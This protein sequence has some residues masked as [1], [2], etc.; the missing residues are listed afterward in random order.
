MRDAYRRATGLVLLL[1]VCVC[2][3]AEADQVLLQLD[4][5]PQHGLAVVDV[6]LTDAARFCELPPVSPSS[7][8]AL[9]LP[10]RTPVPIQ[11]VP[12]ADFDPRHRIAG[13]L[14]L[15]L[16]S[17]GAAE[18]QLQWDAAAADE[19]PTTGGEPFAGQVAT[20]AYRVTH[21]PGRNGGLPCRFEF[22]AGGRV[23]ERFR[24]NDRLHDRAAGSA[25]LAHDPRATVQQVSDGPL[26]TVIRVHARY[27]FPSGQ[28]PESRPQAVYDW[29][30]FR[31]QPLIYVAA[32][33]AQ[34]PAHTWN[35]AHFLELNFPGD[36][37]THWAG[38]EP[39]EQGEFRGETRSFHSDSWG[40]LID[41][42]NAIG[43]LG[44]G[45]VL[46]YDHR[47]GS[48]IQAHGDR[49]WQDWSTSH[50]RWSGWLWVGSDQDAV[51][52]IR[53]AHQA[54]PSQ[55]I[56]TIAAG[57]VQAAIDAARNRWQHS[58]GAERQQ[59]WWHAAGSEQLA[60]QGRFLQAGLAAAGQKPD[61]WTVLQAG[62][63]GAIFDRQPHGIQL[64]SLFDTVTGRQLLS[65]P[66][67]PLFE[68]VLRHAET[69]EEVRL[70][71]DAGWQQVQI[72]PAE[73][74]D[75]L[76]LQWERPQDQRLGAVTVTARAAP[77]AD[78]HSVS[79]RLQ[80]SS[81]DSDWALWRVVF[82][83]NSIAAPGSE[84]QLLV[85]HA[86]GRLEPGAWQRPVRFTGRYPSGWTSMQ[87]MAAYA[88]DGSVGFYT[89]THDPQ[90][91]T[92]ELSAL[93][94][95]DRHAI[96][97]SFDHPVPD[98]GQRG[99]QF[100]LCGQAVWQLFRGDWFDAAVIYRR[101][102]REHAAWFPKLTAEGRS[103][104][105]LWMRQLHVWALG[106]GDPKTGLP[107]LQQFARE[108]GLPV[109]FHWYNWHQIPFDN[110][111]PHYFPADDGFAEAVELLQEKDIYVMPYIN[112]RLW[113][114]HDRGTEDFQ[115]GSLARPAA[116]KDP[117]GQPYIETYGSQESDGN[118]V[119][120][121]AMC[122][123]TELWQSTVR[124]TVLRLMRECQVRGVYIDQVAAAKPELCFDASHAHPAGGGHW[125]TEAYGQMLSDI[126]SEMP[127]DRILTT[128]CN[129]DAYAKWFDGYLTWHWQYDGQ[130]PA[131]PAV[132]GGAIQ[133]FGRA[134][135]GG[136]TKD[137]ALRMKAGQ[138][139]VYGEQ[140]GWLDPGVVREPENFSFLR[141]VV[142]LR[143]RLQR[144]FYAGQMGRPPKLHGQI[145]SVTADWQW[146]GHW[147]VTTAAIQ[148][149]VW[150]LPAE[151]R[152]VAL[153][154]NV[155][156][157]PLALDV[158]LHAD[159]YDLPGD[160]IRVTP[161]AADGP[162]E[163]FAAS[164]DIRRP[165]TIPARTA[166][167]WELDAGQG[168]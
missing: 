71:A 66:S 146:H 57:S 30:Y 10:D 11:F 41:G 46:F 32:T 68:V 113:D 138:Q 75:A 51:A 140:I 148:C 115:F 70:V 47:G 72:A 124:Q 55:A 43:M 131:F 133:M 108:M 145:P 165:I 20:D 135:R 120:L 5:V 69:Q 24:W 132:Y 163:W 8:R 28:A 119:Q 121:A 109:G 154:V 49:A 159:D 35:E 127:E 50:L 97:F 18:L 40:A 122:P 134:Y 94:D 31:D 155:G 17:G 54:A 87:F 125:W 25:G 116:T 100:Q 161:I 33:A 62:Q 36:D 81:G 142:Q 65:S 130:V 141:Q 27:L 103:D 126:R 118:K 158:E 164:P 29:Y 111:Y 168:R 153:L 104:T 42:A 137:L 53:A 23:F 48:Y 93:G 157:E 149:G 16:P 150:Q 64:L 6:D 107:V 26:A 22:S 152:A 117:Q 19:Q 128:E 37:F 80:A 7:L 14:V 83:C 143:H 102:V 112:G 85:P 79:W 78:S 82:P 44:C 86:A 98:M 12:A 167:A 92:K 84:P 39:L 76:Q 52:Q 3:A 147:P 156:D 144:Y 74:A 105:P 13:T 99:N 63:L 1:S 123:S 95:P 91:S 2:A 9:L 136:E 60:R 21:D 151:R 58:T 67:V 96:T 34:Q 139:L 56:A 166:V 160:Q 61:T 38:G 101:W 106:G 89:A 88:G 4:D 77:D 114:T 90:A 45:Q 59:N 73:S 162:Q 110:D 15:R 129:A